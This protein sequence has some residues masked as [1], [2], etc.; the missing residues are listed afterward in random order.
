M[1]AKIREK[2]KD[3]FKSKKSPGVQKPMSIEK[4]IGIG[5]GVIILLGVSAYIFKTYLYP[6]L[7]PTYVSNKEFTMQ[8]NEANS[9]NTSDEPEIAN[10]YYYY[11]QWCPYCKKAR[12]EWDKTKETFEGKVINN[13][14]LQ[15]HEIDCESETNAEMV[16]DID[17]YPTI[18]MFLADGK[19]VFV[20]KRDGSHFQF[21]CTPLK[22]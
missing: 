8:E 20:F 9:K 7:N 6:R 10:I 2:V 13:N 15:F 12:P 5:V 14:K 3:I 21:I 17:G 19:T 16:K 11:T 18:K 4:Y 22:R 1:I